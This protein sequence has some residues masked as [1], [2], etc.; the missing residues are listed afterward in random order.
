MASTV[1]VGAL[2][3]RVRATVSGNSLGQREQILDVY[4]SP[5]TRRPS[6]HRTR[7]RRQWFPPIGRLEGLW[8]VRCDK[9]KGLTLQPK[10]CVISRAAEPRSTLGHDIHHGLEVR[11]RDPR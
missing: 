3:R 2:V 10:N 9:P 1:R 5:V 6:N 8:P 11:R 7:A 4:G